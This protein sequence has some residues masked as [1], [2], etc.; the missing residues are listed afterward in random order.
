M[1]I[2]TNTKNEIISLSADLA[3]VGI[4]SLLE[5]GT[6]KDFPII[7]SL[8]GVIKTG[9]YIKEQLLMKKILHFFKEVKNIPTNKK[10]DFINKLNNDTKYRAKVEESLLLIIDRLNDYSKSEYIG[11]L[12]VA[13]ILGKIDYNTFLKLSNIIDRCYIGDLDN[14]IPFYD[15]N[16]KSIDIDDIDILYNLGVLINTGVSGKTFFYDEGKSVP[17][18][19]P[20][21]EIN[22]YGK[23]IVEIIFKIH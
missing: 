6:L 16:I 19:K 20:Q 21:Y 18:K 3:E 12:F 14:L 5:E 13:T 23:L 2:D 11:K 7:G 15:G 1:D 4:D 9:K 8:I 17:N 22:K 10:T